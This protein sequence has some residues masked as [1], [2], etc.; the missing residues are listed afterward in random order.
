MN[1]KILLLLFVIFIISIMFI[2]CK[3]FD[4]AA[5]VATTAAT[6]TSIDPILGQDYKLQVDTSGGTGI[7]IAIV[8]GTTPTKVG[9]PETIEK[10]YQEKGSS[11]YSFQ[12]GVMSGNLSILSE[13]QIK[14][15]FVRNTPPYLSVRDVICTK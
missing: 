8:S 15:S 13:N 3:K 11:N 1:K 10:L 7:T 9:E 12:T 4:T 6:Y 14:I 5:T 2:S